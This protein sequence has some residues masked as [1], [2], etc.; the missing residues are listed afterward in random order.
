MKLKSRPVQ[1]VLFLCCY[2]LEFGV[3][4]RAVKKP[5]LFVRRVAK[6]A[7]IRRGVFSFF[8]APIASVH[9]FS[10]AA[11]KV[12]RERKKLTNLSYSV[13]RFLFITFSLCFLHFFSTH[14]FSFVLSLRFCNADKYNFGML[15]CSV[16]TVQC[17]LYCVCERPT[18]CI[19]LKVA[20]Q[21]ERR[22]Q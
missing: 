8:V 22:E 19:V 5:V 6:T 1:S 11:M 7:L 9:A 10:D 15:Y 13:S 21:I 4:K 3:F 18:A 17:A 14:S 20:F 12:L 16:V 2:V